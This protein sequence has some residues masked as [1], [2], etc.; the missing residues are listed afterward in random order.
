MDSPIAARND[1]ASCA[2]V[3]VL[4][5]L[6]LEITT[7]PAQMDFQRKTAGP[8]Q[9]PNARPALTGASASG[10]WIQKQVNGL[11]RHL[12]MLQCRGLI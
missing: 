9:F 12:P 7:V 8:K 2:I 10:G 5:N 6:F 3:D 4:T 1:D 11:S